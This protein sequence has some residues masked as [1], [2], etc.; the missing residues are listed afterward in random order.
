MRPFP[1]Q[2]FRMRSSWMQPLRESGTRWWTRAGGE[3]ARVVGT[4][5]VAGTRGWWAMRE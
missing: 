4:R 2:S 3:H 1:L 5:R